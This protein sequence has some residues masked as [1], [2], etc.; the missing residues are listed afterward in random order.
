MCDLRCYV[1]VQE[2]LSVNLS[3]ASDAAHRV[4]SY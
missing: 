1:A 4:C 2:D 3:T